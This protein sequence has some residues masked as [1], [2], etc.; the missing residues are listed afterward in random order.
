MSFSLCKKGLQDL[1]TISAPAYAGLLHWS[2]IIGE[3]IFSKCL[4]K[5][6]WYYVWLKWPLYTFVW[7]RGVEKWGIA[8][9]I[10]EDALTQW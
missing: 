1:A 2:Q 5:L 8:Y 3:R 9:P 7:E 10:L 6:D 4:E